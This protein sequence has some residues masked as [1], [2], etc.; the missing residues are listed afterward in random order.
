[1][2][3][4]Q[5]IVDYLV[6]IYS[7][8]AILLH[9]SR[10]VEKNRPHS[11]W[12]I[13]MLFDKEVIQKRYR[14]EVDGEDVEWK[15]FLIPTEKTDIID[16]FDVYLQFAKVLWE[17]DN[18]GSEL[19]KKALAEY[20]RGPKLSDSQIKREQQFFEHKVSGMKDDKDTPYMFLRHLSV[21]F[22]RSSNLWFEI[23]H[24][25]YSKPFY[26]SIPIIK[27]KDYEYYTHLMTL[28]SNSSPNDEKIIS[29]EWI[30]N[31]LFDKS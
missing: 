27:E 20:S 21:L 8:V 24:N 13:I 14:E 4:T 29:A 10:A 2:D 15:S 12:D 18:A 6:T 28:C 22:N 5:K 30:A 17:K 9:G 31:K 7:P 11:D 1:M 25:E 19:L 26:I 3:K 23:L 16:T